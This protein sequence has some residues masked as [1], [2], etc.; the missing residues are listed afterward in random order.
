MP[1]RSWTPCSRNDV[2][3][4]TPYLSLVIPAYNEGGR[5]AGTVETVRAFL[6]SQAKPYEIIVVDD[7]STDGTTEVVAKLPGIQAISYQ[8]NHGK[9]Y[10]VRRGALASRGEFVAFSDAD[11]SAPIEELP[12]LFEAIEAGADVAIG[13]RALKSSQ[14]LIHQPRYRELGGKALNLVIRMLAVPGIMD[15]Q[16][17]FKLFRGEAARRVFANCILS[18]WGFDV[19]VLYLARRIGCRVVEVPVRWSHSA[20]S[21]IRPFRAGLEVLRDTLRIRFH[22]YGL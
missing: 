22:K 1:R 15:T 6:D 9:G 13:S 20:D 21:K 4:E 10:A 14:L 8:P 2:N 3:G 7:G 17:G 11:L 12:K 5:I 16:C 18:G 19:E